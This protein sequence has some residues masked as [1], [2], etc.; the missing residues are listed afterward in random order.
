VA[1]IPEGLLAVPFV[2]SMLSVTMLLGIGIKVPVLDST[3]YNCLPNVEKAFK[4][5]FPYANL[6]FDIVANEISDCSYET[7]STPSLFFTGGLDATSALIDLIKKKPLLINIWG[8]DLLLSDIEA[9]K[10]LKFYFKQLTNQVGNDYI[11]MKSNCRWYFDQNKLESLLSGII[12]PEHNHGWWASIAHI[13]SMTSTIAPIAYL[14][15]I[16]TNYLGSSYSVHSIG[17]DANNLDMVNAI[18]FGSCAF[19]LIDEN[20]DR[21]EKAKKI[22]KYC[23]TNKLHV[24]LKVCWFSHASENCSHCEKCYRTIAEIV[25]NHADPN[26]YG[27]AITED[28]Y[29]SMRKYL[30]YHYVN[31]A[32]WEDNRRTFQE[33]AEYWK[34]DKRM[35]WIL[36]MKFNDSRRIYL[37]NKYCKIRNF[38][39]RFVC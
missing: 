6:N 15:K 13:L 4:K 21:S 30:K 7:D 39:K 37:Y 14:Y 8:G 2:G 12:H 24:E 10:A 31:E 32:F 33:E 11:F 25:A 9:N 17:F 29:K 1:S 23:E 19:E 26:N 27:F 20:I 3:F 22:V 34:D 5:M 18:K 28:G 16:K 35:S 38:V 36:N